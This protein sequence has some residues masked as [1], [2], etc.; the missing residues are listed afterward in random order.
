MAGLTGSTIADSYDQIVISNNASGGNGSTVITL[1][2]GDGGTTY[3]VS[4][5][6]ASTAKSILSIDGSHANGTALQ[7]DNSATDGDVSIEWQLSG[8]TTWL[9]GIEDGD[10]DSLKICHDSTMGTDERLSLLTASTVFNED[11]ADIDFR[12]ESNGNTAMLFVDGGNNRVGIGT[13]S[14][15]SILE[16]QDGTGTTGSVLTL[17]TKETGV[18]T[19]DVLGRINFYAPLADAAGGGGDQNLVG[20]SIAAVAQAAFSDT[21][22]STALV[23]QT[24]D[25][26]SATTR[27]IIDE[28]GKVTIG[29][30]TYHTNIDVNGNNDPYIQLHDTSNTGEGA[31]ILYDSSAEDLYIG[32]GYEISIKLLAEK[33]SRIVGYQGKIEWDKSMPD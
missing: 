16:I 2:D 15:A 17:G 28:A 33:I 6:D 18:D 23:F 11:Q 4:M 19:D 32:V 3:C 13:A 30:A 10:S 31:T 14:P 29:S 24:G 26:G 20:A 27:M 12:V 25:S 21:V 22:N 8:T 1:Q 9:M 7:I 5:N